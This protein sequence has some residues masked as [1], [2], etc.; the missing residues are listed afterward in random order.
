M[1]QN[2][3]STLNAHIEDAM[4]I[5][6]PVAKWSISA[7]GSILLLI[8][9]LGASHG[10]VAVASR[11]IEMVMVGAIL[12]TSGSFL[13]PRVEKLMRTRENAAFWAITVAILLLT[14]GPA[15]F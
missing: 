2:A 12:L 11:S 7:I 4:K 5:I 15:A 8:G 6:R 10:D 14:F 1:T 3:A 13:A 9:V